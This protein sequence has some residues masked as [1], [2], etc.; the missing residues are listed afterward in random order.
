MAEAKANANAKAKE[1]MHHLR[2][3]DAAG[4]GGIVMTMRG[5]DAGADADADVIADDDG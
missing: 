3:Y 1:N 4:D 2:R 5:A